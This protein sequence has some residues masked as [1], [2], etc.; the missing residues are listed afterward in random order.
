ML[1]IKIDDPGDGCS[2]KMLPV[3]VFFDFE[4]RETHTIGIKTI[5]WHQD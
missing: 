2:G 5:F 3:A 4:L 1:V